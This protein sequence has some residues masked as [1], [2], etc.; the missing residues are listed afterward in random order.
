M[1]GHGNTQD[2]PILESQHPLKEEKKMDK[3]GELCVPKSERNRYPNSL[4]ACSQNMKERQP[5]NS[6]KKKIKKYTL[7]TSTYLGK[8]YFYDYNKQSSIIIMIDKTKTIYTRHFVK[9]RSS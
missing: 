8:L 5:Q 7:S 1:K 9:F 3:V 4:Q 2:F 6:F